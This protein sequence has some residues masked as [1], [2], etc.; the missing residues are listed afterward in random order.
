[1][2]PRPKIPPAL[3][4]ALLASAT[5]LLFLF[6][7]HSPPAASSASAPTVIPPGA[8][9][10]V[11]AAVAAEFLQLEARE[12]S[13]AETVWAQELLAQQHARV[14]EDFWDALNRATN[15]LT[16]AEAFPAAN[17]RLPSFGEPAPGPLGIALRSPSGAARNLSPADCAEFLRVQQAAGWVLEQVEFRHQQFDPPSAGQPPRSGYYFSAHLVNAPLQ[18]R[19]TLEGT[20]RI[21]WQDG[22]NDQGQGVI[23]LLD[24]SQLALRSRPSPPLFTPVL[25]ETITPREGMRA[26]DP[27]LARDLD[28]DGAAEIILAARN[29]V[30]RRAGGHFV[31]GEL[32]RH[33]L[34]FISAAVLGDFDGDGAVDLLADRY[35]GLF[36]FKG[37]PAGTFDAPA[38]RVW[39]PDQPV[40]Y[41]NVLTCG[42]ADADGDLDVFLGQYKEPYDGG[43]TPSPYYDANDGPPAYFL[44][45]DGRGLFSDATAAS[46]L[47]AKRFRRTY[48]ASFADLDGQPGLDLLI[49]SDFAGLDLY[50][51][52]GRGIF[53]DITPSA[54]EN[55][56]AFG[57]AHAV[58]D[59]NS[60]GLLDLLMIGMTSPA[61][62]R[63]EHLGLWRGPREEP[64]QRRAMTHGNHLYLRQPG[65]G[66]RETALSASIARSGWSWGVGALDVENDGFIDAYIANGLESNSSVRDYEAEYWLHDQFITAPS[67]AGRLYFSSKFTRT[68]AKDFSYGG[69]ERNRLFLNQRGQ[70][71]LEAAHLLG[72]ALGEDC[73]N[74]LAED[75]DGDGLTDLILTT[76]EIWPQPR[77][78][79]KI[80]RNNCLNSGNWI[81]FRFRDAP[82]AASPV[83]TQITLHASGQTLTRQI[84]TGDSYR[85]QHTPT[86]HFGLGPLTQIDRARIT[87]PNGQT[88]D[89]LNPAPNRSHLIPSSGGAPSQ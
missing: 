6:L 85:S 71:F 73:R 76:L 1:L 72:V 32:C 64:S 29:L 41:S 63:L 62:D 54:V 4:L 45:N 2:N 14:I 58:N 36:L 53:R 52:N 10:R 67:E 88:L 40:E 13:V 8:T 16:A 19:A 80:F 79:L 86:A 15:K 65:G 57:M 18:T 78:V 48:S 39:K 68:R 82:G 20:L 56:R 70:T 87:W 47:A 84:L 25:S 34:D 3:L 69:Y 5:L 81:A 27:L 17:F 37:S 7:R 49:V 24:A 35:E 22:F 23:T 60:D 44:R 75:L 31:S 83:G 26:I 50:S 59:F 21:T 12:R 89:L 9:N 43:A 55:P 28:G 33:P 74:V 66:F 38:A 42:D 30:Y 46:G 61:V 11:P 51:N 77:Q